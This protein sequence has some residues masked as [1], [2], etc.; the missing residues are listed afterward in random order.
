MMPMA[1]LCLQKY[2]NGRLVSR[3]CIQGEYERV[4]HTYEPEYVL[5]EVNSCNL[6]PTYPPENGGIDREEL[7]RIVR[8]ILIEL[9]EEDARA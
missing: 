6:C 2:V 8:E 3:L 5:S 4:R 1:N 7:K 9:R